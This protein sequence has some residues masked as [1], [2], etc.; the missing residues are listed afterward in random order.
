MGSPFIWWNG[1]VGEDFISE[2]HDRI[3]PNA[4]FQRQY[5][6]LEVDHLPTDGSGHAAILLLCENVVYPFNKPF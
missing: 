3:L 5:N 1:G 2:R 6:H 4:E